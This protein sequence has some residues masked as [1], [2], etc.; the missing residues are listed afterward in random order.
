MKTNKITESRLKKIIRESFESAI[1]EINDP[2]FYTHKREDIQNAMNALTQ[3][4]DAINMCI[5]GDSTDNMSDSDWELSSIRSLV[6]RALM[7]LKR[8]P[9]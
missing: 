2:E 6:H 5:Q 8:F 9:N 3:A 4:Y 1:N 7:Q